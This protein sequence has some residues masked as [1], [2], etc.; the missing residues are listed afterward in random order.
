[1]LY[2][3]YHTRNINPRN[4]AMLMVSDDTHKQEIFNARRG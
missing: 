3:Y 1:M 4:D 2:S